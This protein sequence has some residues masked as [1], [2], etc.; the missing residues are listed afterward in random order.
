[1]L[2]FFFFYIFLKPLT[3]TF[4]ILKATDRHFW[5]TTKVPHI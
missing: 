4:Q 2:N 3:D 5:S 1:M